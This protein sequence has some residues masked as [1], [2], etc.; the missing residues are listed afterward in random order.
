MIKK[1][2]IL[3]LSFM[4][5]N[6]PSMMAQEIQKTQIENEQ[7]PVT[8]SVV[9]NT[10]NVKNAQNLV[11]EVYDITGKKVAAIRIESNDKTY[12]LSVPR[13]CYII[14]I[15]SMARKVYLKD[16]E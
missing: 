15:G 3:S 12:E 14:K 2:L 5:L 11:M 4:L 8:V 6:V 7:L 16:K 9:G 13:G 10:I 1:L